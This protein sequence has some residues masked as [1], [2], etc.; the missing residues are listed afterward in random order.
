MKKNIFTYDFV[1]KT[2]LGTKAD[3]KCAG[4][5]GSAA[6]QELSAMMSA[7]PTFTVVAKI[8]K[9]NTNKKTYKRLYADLCKD[10]TKPV[11][12][13]RFSVSC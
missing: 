13:R 2:I 11:S 9:E 1:D 8:P 5:F 6:Y 4:I 10:F 12:S 3:L 7:Q